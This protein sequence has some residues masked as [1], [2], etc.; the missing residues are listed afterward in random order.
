M[1]TRIIVEQ[2]ADRYHYRVTGCFV[3]EFFTAISTPKLTPLSCATDEVFF[4]SAFPEMHFHRDGGI[5]HTIG[6]GHPV[7]EFVLER[8]GTGD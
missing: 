1:R 2:T 3:H 5:T 7:R 6:R 8:K 4:P